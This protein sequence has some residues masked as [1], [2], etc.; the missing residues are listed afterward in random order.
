MNYY[1]KKCDILAIAR[2]GGDN[3]EIFDKPEIA[4]VALGLDSYFVTAIGHAQD[5]PLLEKIADKTFI[6]PTAFAQYF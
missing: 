6:T 5:V 4:E 1:H 3:L 2:G